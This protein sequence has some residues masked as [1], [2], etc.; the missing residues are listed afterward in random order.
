MVLDA[1]GAL[2]LQPGVLLLFLIAAFPWW[3]TKVMEETCARSRSCPDKIVY[4]L[5]LD[6]G[7]S[8]CVDVMGPAGQL[9]FFNHHGGGDG[10]YWEVALLRSI[11]QG[12]TE[13]LGV[14]T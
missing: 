14:H 5:D 3:E 12:A 10:G 7:T 4:P 8:C 13:I 6:M 9:F 11:Q 1:P 2:E